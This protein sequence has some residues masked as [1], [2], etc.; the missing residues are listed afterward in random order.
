MPASTYAVQSLE[1]AA[2]LLKSFSAAEPE[3]TIGELA[4]RS[5]LPRSTAHRLVVNL[6]RLGFL[7]RGPHSERYRLGL[8]L[9]LIKW[10]PV[11]IWALI[12]ETM[13]TRGHMVRMGYGHIEPSFLTWEWCPEGAEPREW[14]GIAERRHLE[15]SIAEMAAIAAQHQP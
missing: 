9:A 15:F 8:L 14:I 5:H 12:G 13:A 10:Q 2:A 11:A 6:L 4:R 7:A 3:L 1:R